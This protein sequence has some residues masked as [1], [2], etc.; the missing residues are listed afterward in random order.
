MH[1]RGRSMRDGG[2]ALAEARWRGRAGEN[3]LRASFANDGNE[4]ARSGCVGSAGS[5]L[6]LS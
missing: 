3:G 6:L 2:N 1:E 4:P 5:A